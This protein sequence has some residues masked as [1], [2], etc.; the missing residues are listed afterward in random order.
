[1]LPWPYKIDDELLGLSIKTNLCCILPQY[2]TKVLSQGAYYMNNDISWAFEVSIICPLFVVNLCLYYVGKYNS[3]RAISGKRS[4]KLD[5]LFRHPSSMPS[6]V[7]SSP[8]RIPHML[9]K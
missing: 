4:C 6:P 1:M 5:Y 9:E 7:L 2:K 3:P 8:P